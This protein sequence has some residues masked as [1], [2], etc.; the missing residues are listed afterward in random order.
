[1]TVAAGKKKGGSTPVI[2]VSDDCSDVKIFGLSPEKLKE[3]AQ[4]ES[5]KKKYKGA[6]E[7]WGREVLDL[8]GWFQDRPGITARDLDELAFEIVKWRYPQCGFGE[9]MEIGSIPL[10]LYIIVYASV[11][12]YAIAHN[13]APL[14][15]IIDALQEGIVGAFGPLAPEGASASMTV[16]PGLQMV[17]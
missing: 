2:W 12:N 10:N 8:E 16:P 7:K 11:I 17:L 3:K 5:F 15:D 13:I 6:V 9:N 14:K 4:D 1:M